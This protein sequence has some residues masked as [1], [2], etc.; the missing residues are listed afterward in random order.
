MFKPSRFYPSPF[1]HA[2]PELMHTAKKLRNSVL[3]RECF[4]HVVGRWA[5][6][7]LRASFPDAPSR[8]TGRERQ[9]IE[10]DDDVF[11]LVIDACLDIQTSILDLNNH[12]LV[13]S[14]KRDLPLDDFDSGLA[15][16][17]F[18]KFPTR[19]LHFWRDVKK[20]VDRRIAEDENASPALRVL[21]ADLRFIMTNNLSLDKRMKGSG[22]TTSS[23]LK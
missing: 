4:I 13:A 11:R 20:A 14:V 16:N 9:L 8:L 3:F 2:A 12:L 18:G 22:V 5:S 19:N 17:R 23:V 6:R 15:N 1:A 10:E 7:G 21:D